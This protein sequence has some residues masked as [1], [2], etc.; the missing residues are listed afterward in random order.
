MI[1]VQRAIVQIVFKSR[2]KKFQFF[3]WYSK[4]KGE[5]TIKGHLTSTPLSGQ[6]EIFVYLTFAD[7]LKCR[8]ISIVRQVKMKKFH[9]G[10]LH[11]LQ[12]G[13]YPEA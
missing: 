3:H 12:Q 1:I 7:I 2:K 5:K 8:L 4:E 9:F 6:P 11:Y 10:R 13:K